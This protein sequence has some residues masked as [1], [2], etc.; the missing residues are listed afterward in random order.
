MLKNTIRISLTMFIFLAMVTSIQ[1]KKAGEVTDGVFHD[2]KFGY[3]MSFPGGW[4]ENVKSEKSALRVILAE[5]SY[6]IPRHFQGAGKEDY[7][8]IPTIAILADTTSLTAQQF[9]DSLLNAED[10]SKQLEYFERNTRIISRPYEVEKRQGLT[11]DEQEGYLVQAR[12]QYS[13]EVAER[14]SDRADIVNDY[15]AGFVFAMVKDGTVI[16]VNGICERS[17]IS[18]YMPVFLDVVQSIKFE[19]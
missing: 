4:G 1:A 3:T 15:K 5:K 12:Q 17:F 7:A 6:P 10:K 13:M 2:E 9:I 14:G 8:T 16:A 18:N 19:E 11:V